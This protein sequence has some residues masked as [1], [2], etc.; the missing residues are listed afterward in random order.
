[1]GAERASNFSLGAA[2]SWSQALS[3][4]MAFFHRDVRD[5]ITY[6]LGDGGVGQYQNLGHTTM[7]GLDASLKWQPTAWLE[8][9]PSYT[10]MTAKDVDTGLCLAAKPEHKLSL[11]V[12][13]RP[14][15][16]W[17]LGLVYS[18]ESQ[19]FTRSDNTEF[20]DPYHK[21]DMRCE[22]R[23]GKYRLFTTVENLLD[24]EYLY[25]DGYPA[26]PRTWLLGLSREF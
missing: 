18:Y 26:P 8:I 15:G 5:S 10:Y 23:L 24:A 9:K 7:S 3:G 2:S 11:D 12:L 4:D 17:A 21:L 6:V 25:G 13:W 20:A 19:R 22:Y 14:A 16:G 1:L